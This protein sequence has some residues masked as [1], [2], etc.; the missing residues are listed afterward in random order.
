LF[1]KRVND[2]IYENIFLLKENSTMYRVCVPAT[3]ANLG[4]G[5][6]SLG[7]ALKIYNS[8]YFTE[9]KEGLKFSIINRDTGTELEL[10]NNDNLV[11]TAMS[12]VF[13]RYG[14]D[15]K[16][17]ELREEVSIP[18][19]RGLGSSATAVI[20]GL[21]GAN[22]IL[23]NPLNDQEILELAT[24]ME[25]HPDNVVPAFKGGFIINVQTPRGLIYRKLEIASELQAVVVVPDFELKTEELRKLLPESISYQDAIFNHSRT[26]L[27]AASICGNN[28]QQL[29][30]AMEDRLHQDYRAK[31]IPGFYQ[32]IEKAYQQGALG[33][34]LSGAGP[35][36]LALTISNPEGIGEAMVAA[37]ARA[38]ITS[39]YIITGP[40]NK[41][42]IIE[43]TDKILV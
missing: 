24:E 25:G 9:I 22:L 2:K 15:L 40:D 6:D 7:L 39:K 42:T 30:I 35:A 8:F 29:A 41:G 16:G 5:Y 28:Y 18:F 19:A 4:P 38:G 20:A 17:I 32:V 34:A 43:K 33:V 1:F 14:R 10:K 21:V 13:R 26:A 36:I 37:F 23:D 12:K 31:L 3:S 27:L 11:F